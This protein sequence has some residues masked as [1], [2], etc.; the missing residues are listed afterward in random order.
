MQH[1]EEIY[2][3]STKQQ[4]TITNSTF[5]KVVYT[6]QILIMHYVEYKNTYDQFVNKYNVLSVN[7]SLITSVKNELGKAQIATERY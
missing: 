6:K 5:T 4:I 7:I 1:K 2:K 3:V